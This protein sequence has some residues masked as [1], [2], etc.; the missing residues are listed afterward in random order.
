MELGCSVT[1]IV[2]LT[3]Q[4]YWIYIPTTAKDRGVLNI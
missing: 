3:V 4:R 1:K 2:L